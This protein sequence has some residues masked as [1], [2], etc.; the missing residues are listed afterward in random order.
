MQHAIDRGHGGPYHYIDA[1]AFRETSFALEVVL[2]AA[3]RTYISDGGGGQDPRPATSNDWSAASND[4]W[5]FR[6]K[7]RWLAHLKRIGYGRGGGGDGGDDVPEDHARPEIHSATKRFE[8]FGSE[9]LTLW[10][11]LFRYD[12]GAF[13]MGRY[14]MPCYCDL[15][16]PGCLQGLGRALCVDAPSSVFRDAMRRLGGL[17][18]TRN[19]Y[20]RGGAVDAWICVRCPIKDQR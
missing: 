2:M 3:R 4:W 16:L 1:I 8:A 12:R 18:S 17:D 19:L 10:E 7:A 13:W 5:E 15:P 14:T 6:I 11:Y 20:E 9:E